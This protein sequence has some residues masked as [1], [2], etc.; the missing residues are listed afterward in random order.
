MQLLTYLTSHSFI[1]SKV[2]QL[3]KQHSN[4]KP[5]FGLHPW[6]ITRPAIERE[7]VLYIAAVFFVQLSLPYDT[8]CKSQDNA[9]Q[10]LVRQVRQMA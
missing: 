6:Y 10:V 9:L 8:L 4:I 5:N 7:P 3:A 1:V 2:A